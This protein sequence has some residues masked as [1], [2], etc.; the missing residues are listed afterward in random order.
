MFAIAFTNQGVGSA[1]IFE[2]DV[3]VD[4]LSKGRVILIVGLFMQLV[5]FAVSCPI[6]TMN[7]HL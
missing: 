6:L 5:A 2:A 3:D 4:Q 1:I 7:S